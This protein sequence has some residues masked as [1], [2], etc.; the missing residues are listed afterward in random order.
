MKI[1]CEKN[2]NFIP[3]INKNGEK[4]Y[5]IYSGLPTAVKLVDTY[6]APCG[7]VCGEFRLATGRT[8]QGKLESEYMSR[9]TPYA[10]EG[11]IVRF[12]E[13]VNGEKK[14]YNAFA[15]LDDLKIGKTI[16]FDYIEHI[17]VFGPWTKV[18]KKDSYKGWELVAGYWYVYTDTGTIRECHETYNKLVF[19]KT[20][21]W[22]FS[23][24]K[25]KTQTIYKDCVFGSYTEAE[26]YLS[27]KLSKKDVVDF[28]DEE[29][30]EEP[31]TKTI[32]LDVNGEKKTKEIPEELMGK[33]IKMVYGK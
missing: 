28:E 29:E 17:D 26:K 9:D 10:T 30:V 18:E 22:C 8:T 14:R 3:T 13:E 5:I 19:D 33:I 21:G 24:E 12:T 20:F 2:G 7:D 15:N 6:L 32:T 16:R 4:F 31:E 1:T 25:Q 11:Y 23:T 27:M